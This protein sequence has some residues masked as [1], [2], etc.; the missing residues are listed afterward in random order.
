MIT[1]EI[2]KQKISELSEDVFSLYTSIEITQAIK[3]VLLTYK[4]SKKDEFVDC[5]GD[6]LIGLLPPGEFE[7]ALASVFGV[8]PD[9]VTKI[10]QTFKP[11]FDKAK[12]VTY[13]EANLETKERLELK[14]KPN[15]GTVAQK[16]VASDT[17]AKPL[18]REEL[19]SALAGKRTMAA[20][21]EALRKKQEEGK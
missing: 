3:Q 13:P 14:P 7:K 8:H 19:M 17:P 1:N 16:Q 2:R 11:F 20:D 18:T 12:G 9:H 4:I 6:T 5:V 21:I 10:T 15:D